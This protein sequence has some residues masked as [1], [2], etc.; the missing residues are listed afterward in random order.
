MVSRRPVPAH[1]AEFFL[2]SGGR[3]FFLLRIATVGT[4]S[5]QAAWRRQIFST[6][7]EITI[8]ISLLREP[9]PNRLQNLPHSFP[10]K[11]NLIRTSFFK[12]LFVWLIIVIITH[13]FC[14]FKCIY[15]LLSHIF[16]SSGSSLIYNGIYVTP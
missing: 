11:E 2:L 14:L 7:N 6:C 4:V 8:N 12:L 3:A 9:F 15:F 1:Q 16:C 10:C 13:L 5:V